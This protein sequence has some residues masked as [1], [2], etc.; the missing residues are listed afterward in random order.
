MGD[1]AMAVRESTELG[2]LANLGQAANGIAAL[3]LFA[4]YR[5]R[6]AER[7]V[8]RQDA[9]LALF[10]EYLASKPGVTVGDLAH[11]PEAWQPITW[12]LVTGYRQWMLH[13]GY[14]VGSVNVRL[15]TIRTY[16]KLAMK[17]GALDADEY[18]RI[19]AVEG[20]DSTESKR[21]NSARDA[22]T[23]CLCTCCSTWG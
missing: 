22:G 21:I 18:T 5:S 7:T 12:G 4:D 16:A 8:K 2:A 15:S 14:A 23:P 3:N 10:A 19:R 17:A 11:D 1:S 9:D 13:Q 6:K 20:Y